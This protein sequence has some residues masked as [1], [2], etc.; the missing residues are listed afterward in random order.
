MLSNAIEIEDKIVNELGFNGL[1]EFARE[2]DLHFHEVND[3]F[4]GNRIHQN[5]LLTL[6]KNGIRYEFSRRK[7]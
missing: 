4:Y 2:S 1:R 7:K 5:V 6:Q 3:T